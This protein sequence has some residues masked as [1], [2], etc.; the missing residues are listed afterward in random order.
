MRGTFFSNRCPFAASGSFHSDSSTLPQ[1]QL[2]VALTDPIMRATTN[3]MVNEVFP[4]LDMALTFGGPAFDNIVQGGGALQASWAGDELGRHLFRYQERGLHHMIQI[5]AGWVQEAG[6]NSLVNSLNHVA[7]NFARQPVHEIPNPSIYLT[8]ARARDPARV[9]DLPA[10][11]TTLSQ[12][13]GLVEMCDGTFLDRELANFFEAENPGFHEAQA[14]NQTPVNHHHALGSLCSVRTAIARNDGQLLG[15]WRCN[16]CGDNYGVRHDYNSMCTACGTSAAR[17][18]QVNGVDPMIRGFC[19]YCNNSGQYNMRHRCPNH[20]TASQP[21]YTLAVPNDDFVYEASG[22]PTILVRGQ[23]L[24]TGSYDRSY[25]QLEGGLVDV[26][27]NEAV[28]LLNRYATQIAARGLEAG[29][30]YAARVGLERFVFR[31]QQG[32]AIGAVR[33]IL[34]P[35]AI[36]GVSGLMKAL[37]RLLHVTTNNEVVVT[38][39]NELQDGS[40]EFNGYRYEGVPIPV[41]EAADEDNV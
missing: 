4:N 26:I 25:T 35:L 40:F 9:R 11:D 17:F 13:T 8:P 24:L 41:M 19:R 30:E 32:G 29:L 38:T 5:G 7:A 15:Y 33:P 27:R 31:R 37:L 10:S 6:V 1:Y 16:E 2:A 21:V 28:T 20:P 22:S 18:C 3:W 14:I 23:N 12:I 36:V 39:N 34:Q